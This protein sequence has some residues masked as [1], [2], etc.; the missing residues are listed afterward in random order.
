MMISLIFGVFLV[1]S[2]GFLSFILFVPPKTLLV[3]DQFF[4]TTQQLPL[5]VAA[6]ILLIAFYSSPLTTLY[7]VLKSRNSRSFYFPLAL[8]SL[9][10][11]ISWCVMGVILQDWFIVGPNVVTT[12]FAL[13][14]V[15]CCVIFPKRKL[16]EDDSGS[17]KQM[18]IA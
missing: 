11:R 7:K 16:D 2:A 6:N 3:H 18:D 10:A 9:T 5:G 1:I 17:V 15:L 14:Q 8:A 13:I 4:T 12:L